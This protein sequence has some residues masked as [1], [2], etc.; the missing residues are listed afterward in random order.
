M[1]GA[2]GPSNIGHGHGS[3]WPP[4]GSIAQPADSKGGVGF[5]LRSNRLRPEQLPGGPARPPLQP[6]LGE[7][8]QVWLP[9]SFLWVC[10]LVLLL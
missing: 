1:S 8:V 10:S 4:G 7:L 3:L 6:G 5:W 2:D 9:S